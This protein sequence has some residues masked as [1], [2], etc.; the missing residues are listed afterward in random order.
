MQFMIHSLNLYANFSIYINLNS[1]QERV[2][3]RNMNR[4][5]KYHATKL[6][7]SCHMIGAHL[8]QLAMNFQSLENPM[9]HRNQIPQLCL[10]TNFAAP[11][12]YTSS[13]ANTHIISIKIFM[14]EDSQLC[15]N[16]QNLF[17]YIQKS[18]CSPLPSC[19]QLELPFLP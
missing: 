10:G 12:W 15:N 6:V 19:S 16:K 11:A 18:N 5:T 14:S 2:Q 1:S 13:P 17:K 4:F 9:Y 3:T 8:S 7:P